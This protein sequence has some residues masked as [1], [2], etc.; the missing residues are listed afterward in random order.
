M[1]VFLKYLK[2][3][4]QLAVLALLL[5]AASQVLALLDPIILGW[6]IDGY[7]SRLHYFSEFVGSSINGEI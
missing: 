6:L 1:H 5:A 3:Q 2:P 7:G 4:R